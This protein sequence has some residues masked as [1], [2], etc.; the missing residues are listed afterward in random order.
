MYF[1]S[2]DDSLL[3]RY[4]LVPYGNHSYLESLTDKSKVLIAIIFIIILQIVHKFCLFLNI[5]LHIVFHS[6]TASVLF[7]RLEVLLG[8]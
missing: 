1:F 6:G 7:R 8:Q 2:K 5:S 3:S 4:R